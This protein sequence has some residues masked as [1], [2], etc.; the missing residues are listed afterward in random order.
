MGHEKPRFPYLPLDVDRLTSDELVE[1]MT[2][3]EFGAYI[4]LMC[5]A[6]KS[7]PPCTLP[8]DDR[9]LAKLARMTDRDWKRVK[10]RVLAPWKVN[11]EGRIYQKRLLEVYQ[12]VMQ[13][14]E[15][16]KANG[17][18]G[19]KAKAAKSTSNNPSLAIATLQQN[20]SD[21]IATPVAN[22]YQRK[23]KGNNTSY[24]VL[25]PNPPGAEKVAVAEDDLT[26]SDEGH[27]ANT[28]I[29]DLTG[30][31]H[32]DTDPLRW[33]AEFIRSWNSLPG[34]S[35]HSGGA[36]S[37]PNYVELRKRLTCSDWDWEAAFQKMKLAPL[38]FPE[39]KLPN[40]TFF[41]K[42]DSVSKILDNTY[43]TKRTKQAGLFGRAQPSEVTRVRTGELDS[44]VT[45][46]FAK[47]AAASGAGS[48]N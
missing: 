27:S 46:A 48:E 9:T 34:V 29:T 12:E 16:N 18:K 33:V 15:K 38:D 26:T 35:E 3:E 1:A 10:D 13:K 43:A 23:G 28:Y 32:I 8:Q 11:P 47:A 25:P 36:L 2:T 19:G 14:V 4:F 7:N 21:A 24:E 39:G 17:A 40:I 22:G 42:W 41:L 31:F 20:P 44:F 37:S 5:K 6:W 30:T 45:D